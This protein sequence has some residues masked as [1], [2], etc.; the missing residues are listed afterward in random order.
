MKDRPHAEIVNDVA[1]LIISRLISRALFRADDEIILKA[2]VRLNE[3]AAREGE[4]DYIRMWREIVYAPPERIMQVLRSR[5]E[6]AYWLRLTS[7]FSATDAGYPIRDIEF[8]R[9]IWR[10]ARRLVLR[11]HSR[12]RQPPGMGECDTQHPNAGYGPNPD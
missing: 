8:R 4:T 10:D 11:G 6:E 5:D 7:P 1:K 3:K 9:R 2:R 12:H